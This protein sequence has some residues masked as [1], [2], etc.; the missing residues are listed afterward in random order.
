[1]FVPFDKLG[2]HARLWIYQANRDFNSDELKIISEALRSFT[3]RWLV[4]GQPMHASF[5]IR[6]N[7]FIIIAADEKANAASGCSIDDSV[8][9]LK[10]LA[11]SLN[12]DFFDRTLIAFHD[13]EKVFT[14]P[15]SELKSAAK[16]GTWNATTPTFNNLVATKKELEQQWIVPAGNTWLKRYLTQASVAS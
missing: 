1:M 12:V 5:E 13:G 8:R 11:G 4:H 10:G 6:W 14:I 3:D 7:R 2:D 9:T 16:A 15:S